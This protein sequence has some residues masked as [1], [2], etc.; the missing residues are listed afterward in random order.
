MQSGAKLESSASERTVLVVL[1]GEAVGGASLSVLRLIP[2]LERRGWRFVF[3]APRP[4]ALYDE[5]VARGLDAHGEPRGLI[6]YSW[7][8]LRVPPGVARRL[9]RL[10]RYF[11]SLRRLI[12]ETRPAL[13]HANSLYT[14]GEALTAR[15]L[16]VPTVFHVHEMVRPNAK[17]RI[18]RRLAHTFNDV[19]I[20]VSDSGAAALST[21]GSRAKVVYECVSIPSEVPVREDRKGRSVIGTVGVVSRRKGSDLFVEA[22]RL[23]REQKDEIEF[24]MVGSADDPLDAAWA[25]DLL[26]RLP[27]VGIEHE[28]SAD[29]AAELAG[30]D[31]F[32]LPSR[33]DPFPIVVLEAMASELPV[34]GTRVDGIAEQVTPETGILVEADDP[35]ALAAAILELHRNPERRREMGRAGRARVAERFSLERQAQGIHEAYLEA[36]GRK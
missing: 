13:V 15:A 32:V 7:Q 27:A 8:A 35:D 1:H 9:A 22:A 33:S 16:R 17:G 5:L 34:I 11:G 6:G 21:D 24:R 26:A 12:K 3:W 20:G 2:E 36:L 10:P 29:V 23:V 31:A 28:P 25:S 14:L 30:W 19:V 18:A 4:S